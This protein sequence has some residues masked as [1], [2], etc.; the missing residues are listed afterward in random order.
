MGDAAPK[1]ESLN[2][3]PLWRSKHVAAYLDMSISWVKKQVALNKP[4]GLPF[5]RV[6]GH[7]IRFDPEKIKAWAESGKS[8]KVVAFKSER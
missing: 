3:T 2:E 1:M 5:M 6:G 8:G 4:G 7:A